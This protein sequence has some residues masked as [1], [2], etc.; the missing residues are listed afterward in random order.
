MQSGESRW[1]FGTQKTQGCI[2]I[3][4]IG[5]SESIGA[6]HSIIFVKA[7]TGRTVVMSNLDEKGKKIEGSAHQEQSPCENFQGTL[8]RNGGK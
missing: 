5:S 2:N 7:G 4:H 3:S 8:D 6:W 1:H